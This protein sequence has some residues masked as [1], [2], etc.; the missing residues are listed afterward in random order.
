MRRV[1]SV[2]SVGPVTGARL[3]IS[4][5]RGL[6]G[7]GLLGLLSLCRWLRLGIWR[8]RRRRVRRSRAGTGGTGVGTRGSGVVAGL[9]FIPGSGSNAA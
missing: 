5:F 9:L 1:R 7:L 3:W 2:R 4:I 8:F 6:A